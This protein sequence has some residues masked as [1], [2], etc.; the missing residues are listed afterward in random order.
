MSFW[1]TSAGAPSMWSVYFGDRTPRLLRDGPPPTPPAVWHD[2]RSGDELV[3]RRLFAADGRD[4]AAF[5]ENYYCGVG[6]RYTSVEKWIHRYLGDPSVVAIGFFRRGAG[7]PELMATMIAVP[8]SGTRMS[9]G[10]SPRM[11]VFE[12]LC[13]HP[14]YRGQG[15]I[16]AALG[17]M[18][19]LLHR[20]NG[21]TAGLWCRDLDTAP[22]FSTAIST[23]SYGF[24]RCGG[25]PAGAGVLEPM[26]W[27]EFARLWERDSMGWLS[28]GGSGGGAEGVVV[29]PVA[30]NRRG[31][32]RVFRYSR[33]AALEEESQVICVGDTGRIS[34]PDSLPIY[35]I[36][37]CG[38]L[39]TSSKLCAAKKGADFQHALNAVAAVL[40]RGLLFGTDAPNGGGV[41]VWWADWMVGRSGCV[42]WYMYNFVPPCYGATRLH[43]VRDEL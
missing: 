35:E 6:W 11:M 26:E 2:T 1:A 10:G 25:A 24:R 41:C 30:E 19:A 13:V 28:S 15:L 18:D 20:M 42:A 21:Y 34:V 12:G 38:T 39:D 37:W 36:M 29:A 40:G 17:Y 32:M 9:H 23:A 8:L 14:S 16:H 4:V 31:T 22:F 27:G 5:L 3:P 43:I 7:L 33:A